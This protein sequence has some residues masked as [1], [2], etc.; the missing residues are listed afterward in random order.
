L[1][2]SIRGVMWFGNSGGVSNDIGLYC[3]LLNIGGQCTRL[4]AIRYDSDSTHV[5]N[6]VDHLPVRRHYS[7]RGADA[8]L[9]KCEN[10]VEGGDGQT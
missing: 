2:G 1:S 9:N 7:E 10:C 5:R 3:I 4:L 6:N 8:F